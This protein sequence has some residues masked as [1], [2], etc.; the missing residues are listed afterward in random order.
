MRD[1]KLENVKDALQVIAKLE[2]LLKMNEIYDTRDLDKIQDI[3]WKKYKEST[4]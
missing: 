2:L 4:M 1:T 3:L